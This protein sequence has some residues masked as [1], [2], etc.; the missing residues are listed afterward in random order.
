MMI[1][2]GDISGIQNYVFDVAEEGGGQARRLRARSFFV[3]LLAE[4]AALHVRRALGWGPEAVL[5]CG[6]SKFT[7]RGSCAGSADGLLAAEQQAIND[8]LRRETAGELRLTLAWAQVAESDNVAYQAAQHELQRR[9]AQPWAPALGAGWADSRLLLD[10]LDTPCSLCHHAPATEEEID[11]DGVPRLVCRTCSRNRVLG[12]MLP[13]ARWLVIQDGS[14]ADDLAMFGLRIDVVTN[15]SVTIGPGTLAVANLQESETCPSWCPRDRFMQRRLMAH[16]PVHNDGQPV[17]FT[18]L[19]ETHSQGDPLLAVLKADADSLGVQFEHLL[20]SGGLDAMRA[21]SDRLDEFFAGRLRRELAR[22]NDR[23]WPI[24]TIFAGG[25]DLIMVGPWNVMVDFAGTMRHWFTE[26]FGDH[27]LTLSAGLELMKPKRPIKPA[28]ERA[29]LLLK[30]AKDSG[31]D[32]LAAFGQVWPWKDHNTIID[33]ARQLV[34][35]ANAGDIQRG[36]LHTLLEHALARHSDKPE[37][38]ATARLAY[39]VDRN[40]KKGTPACRWANQLI[41][42]FDDPNNIQVR[43]LPAIVRY[44]LTATRTRGEEY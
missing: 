27:G 12:Q 20:N 6:A 31:K 23:W 34:E 21:L 7:L 5:L 24:Y 40:W 13:R 9:K 43:Y 14:Q 44:A 19:A 1:V 29:E 39:H 16:V 2:L 8:W 33:A 37:P 36:W 22:R 38:L 28:V 41:S 42:I 11:P 26:E 3:Q 10:P 35:W 25:D 17:W 32:R 15:D 4:S 18:E 30:E